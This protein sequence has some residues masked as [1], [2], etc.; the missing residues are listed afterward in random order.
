MMTYK[1]GRFLLRVDPR[2]HRRLFELSAEAGESLNA[3]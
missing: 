1:S 3:W 2:L